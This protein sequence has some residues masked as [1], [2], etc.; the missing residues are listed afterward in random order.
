MTILSEVVVKAL[1]FVGAHEIRV[2]LAGISRYLCK[3]SRRIFTAPPSQGV[4]W[5][6]I[7]VPPAVATGGLKRVD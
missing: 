6:N 3:L 2:R 5:S 7:K 4:A 1:R